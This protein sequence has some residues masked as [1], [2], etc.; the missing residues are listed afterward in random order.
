MPIIV[1]I[2]TKQP[3]PWRL[4]HT[5]HANHPYSKGQSK[6]TSW[7]G[8]GHLKTVTNFCGCST[9]LSSKVSS[10]TKYCA[11]MAAHSRRTHRL[12]KL[13]KQA[14]SV[15]DK[16]AGLSGDIGREKDIIDYVSHPLHTVIITRGAYS[17]KDGSFP[18]LGE[19]ACRSAVI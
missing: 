17:V 8:F 3:P 19:T 10:S 12:D 1:P 4:K 5:T 9:S 14:G 16:K 15:V 18:N 11:R 7:G 6:L 2:D 13:I